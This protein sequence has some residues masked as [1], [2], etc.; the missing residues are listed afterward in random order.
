ME[1]ASHTESFWTICP[2]CHG[3]G[4]IWKNASRKK[5]RF[6]RS[7]REKQISDPTITP[8]RGS[9]HACPD[10]RGTGLEA[11]R[12][13]SEP[14]PA[15]YPH[16][17]IIGGGIGG[18]ALA[19]AC[20]H[21]GIPFTLYERDGNFAARPQG[22]GLTLQQ[23]SKAIQGLGIFSLPEGLT[24][25]RHVVHNADGKIIGEWGVRKWKKEVMAETTKR[26]NVHISRQSLRLSL[27]EN[28]PSKYIQW[29]HSLVDITHTNTSATL[30]FEAQEERKT[31]QADLVVGA[32]GIRSRVRDYLIG[33]G[34][35][36][37]R[38]LD[39]IVIL[40][41]CP[42]GSLHHLESPLLDSATVFQS[43]NGHERIYAMPYDKDTIM[44]QAS[45]PM[46]ESEARALSAKGADAMKEEVMQRFNWHTPIPEILS[47]TPTSRI[48]GYPVYDRTLFDPALLENAGPIT[49]L[50][51]AAH[52]MS[53]FKG[54]G[55]NQALLDALLLA[56]NIAVTCD[57]NPRWRE[58]GIRETV[59]NA[60]EQE[61]ARRSA[62]KVKDS[63]RAAKLLHT[64]AALQER[65]TP[66]GR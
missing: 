60:F 9:T 17:A 23:A 57:T 58:T 32:D 42:L 62:S 16:I 65:D 8:P 39:C 11:A 36:P 26:K 14:N 30:T 44:W 61:M 10:C 31:V 56:R 43:V 4:K 59:L 27:L 53:P 33:E 1:T 6:F 19:A 66:R 48:T 3:Q 34:K 46:E 40:G 51:D 7:L 63:A 18:T 50:G 24:S 2:E 47:E 64:D 22:Y 41:I 5:R 45:F 28:I 29:G 35:T 21:R 38:Y 20:L 15:A 12:K 37:L 25:T 55:A 52:P 49:L 13:A 54:Q